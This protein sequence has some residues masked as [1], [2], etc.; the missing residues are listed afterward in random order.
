MHNDVDKRRIGLILPSINIRMEPE[1]YR[2][3]QLSEFNFYTTRVMMG[4]ITETALKEM[5][6]DLESAARMLA[7]VVPEAIIFG[8]TSGS[9]ISGG[10]QNHMI[11]QKVE[12]ICGCPVIT[13][14]QAMLDAIKVL[15]VKRL[16]LATP[17]TEDINQKEKAF[18]EA[19]GIQV[20]AMKGWQIVPYE[21][22]RTQTVE[23]TEKLVLETDAPESDAVFISCTN[24]EGFHICENL[25][26]KIGKP[27]LSSNLVCL[28]ALLR[29]INNEVVIDDRG[30]LLR[31]YLH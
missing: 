26:K 21:E 25:E 30:I 28:W 20:V 31:E 10:G 22:L 5:E 11:V 12:D 6:L 7:T 29:A 3:P 18:L 1:Y 17:Y 23:R 16:T 2:C 24:I 4:G 8:C 9:F 27:V 15:K 14:S 13:A 19:N